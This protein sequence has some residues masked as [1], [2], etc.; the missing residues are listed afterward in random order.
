MLKTGSHLKLSIFDDFRND[1]DIIIQA[2]KF[3]S[4]E[5]KIQVGTKKK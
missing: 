2:V 5:I 1:Q 3:D 4:E